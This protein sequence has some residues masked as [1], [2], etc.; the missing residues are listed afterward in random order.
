MTT[1]FIGKAA[2]AALADFDGCTD[3]LGLSGGKN[4]GREYLPKNPTR[5][6][7]APGSFS[8][9]RDTGAWSDFATG[10]KGGDLVSLVA[11]VLGCRQIEAA[12]RLA[13]HYGIA[14]PD[15]QKRSPGDERGGGHA[16]TSTPLPNAPTSP[17]C[18]QADIAPVCV[19]PIPA[20]AP[21]PPSKT[22]GSSNHSTNQLSVSTF[23]VAADM[24]ALRCI[25]YEGLI[26]AHF[27]VLIHDNRKLTDADLEILVAT[28][29]RVQS[30]LTAAGL[31]AS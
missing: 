27:G 15:R 19:M 24:D 1:D 4:Q 17:P 20:D 10:D 12:E 5:A 18:G 29:T 13:D 11:F 8:I 25:A 22:T 7:H 21:P 14:K 30:A 26:I 31:G 16:K 23:N 9:N 28:V 6:D 2:A 3:W